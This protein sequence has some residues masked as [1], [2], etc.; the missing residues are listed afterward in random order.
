MLT[1]ER[2]EAGLSMV[3]LPKLHHIATL[4][5]NFGISSTRVPEPDE[6]ETILP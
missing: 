6:S 5:F 1:R 3:V 4:V 2:G